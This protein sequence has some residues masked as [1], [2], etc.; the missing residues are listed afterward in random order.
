MPASTAAAGWR[1]TRTST[2]GNQTFY[3][4]QIEDVHA[5]KTRSHALRPGRASRQLLPALPSTRRHVY[6]YADVRLGL[7]RR[8][9]RGERHV[10]QTAING[11]ALFNNRLVTITID[12]PDTYGPLG[13]D[14]RATSQRAGLV[15]DRV[16]HQRRQR[17]DDLGGRHPGQ[18]GPPRPALTWHPPWGCARSWLGS[19]AR[20]RP[21]V[22][23]SR[24]S[25]RHDRR[26][27]RRQR[28]RV[29][30]ADL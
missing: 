27:A 30:S 21:G 7:R 19:D 17:H 1:P 3:F 26:G 9:T 2:A 29:P 24:R 22:T 11:A 4:S 13:L 8:P 15:A 25:R 5:G 14:P 23:L 6:H 20:P 12:L 18:P 28:Y 16:R 10:L